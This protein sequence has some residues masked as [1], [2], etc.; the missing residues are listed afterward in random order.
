MKKVVKELLFFVFILL[1]I[2]PLRVLALSNETSYIGI[3]ETT[4]LSVGDLSFTNL[5]FK[6]YSDTSSL[7][8][9]V[10]GLLTN[11]SS[12]EI[13]YTSLV[14]Y[15]DNSY[16]LIASS[17]NSYKAIPDLTSFNQMSNLSKLGDYNVSDVSYFKLLIEINSDIQETGNISNLA[18]SKNSKYSSYD[19]VIDK[20][21][22]NIIVNENNT[23]DI[24]E[25]IT[26]YFN[27]SKH[28]IYRTIPLKNKITR[29]DGTTS[30][31]KVQVTNV[32]VDNEYTTSKENGNYKIKIGSSNYT[33]T[34]EKTYT[35]KYTY[36]LGKDPIKDYDE[37]YY[38]II[39]SE[40]D[41]VIGNVTFSITMPK[42]FDA[43]KLGFS[44]GEFGSTDN[45]DVSY[46][47]KDNT[48]T[49]S[50]DDILDVG[51][52]L[53]VRCELEKGYFV[54]AGL[55]IN[56]FDYIL[57]LIPILL[58]AIAILIWY[59]YGRDDVVVETV[60]FYPPEGL[61]S[62][63]VGFLYK[64]E[65]E[66]KDVTSLLVYLANKGYLKIID[67]N[68]DANFDKVKLSDEEISKAKEKIVELQAKIEE[69]KSNNP[70]SSK[71]KYY[72][73]MI[74]IYKNIDTPVDYQ[75]YGV[76]RTMNS[77][78]IFD[79]FI[80]EDRYKI[81]KI[82]DYDGNNMF[83]RWFMDGLFEEGCSETSESKLF[84]N[85]YHTINRIKNNIKRNSKKVFE[86]KPK[87]ISCVLILLMVMSIF[88][89]LFVPLLRYN[90]FDEL[91][92]Y[93]FIVLFFLFAFLS[94]NLNNYS[95]AFK[96]LFNLFF[97]YFI[98]GFFWTSLLKQTLSESLINLPSII[99]NLT[100]LFGITLCLLFLDKR[101]PYGTEMLGKIRGFKNFLESAE[102]E[103]LD[104]LVLQNPTY[105]YD[106]LPYT[107]VLGVSK[108]WIK[109]FETMAL[110]APDWYD[111]SNFDLREFDRVMGFTMSSCE[112][113][114][115]TNSSNDTFISHNDSPNNTSS[116]GGGSS[117]GGSGGGGGGSW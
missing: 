6:N 58:L 39:G 49:G 30:T 102:K 52:A 4:S 63:E 85:F 9:G 111:S 110:Q 1:I 8:F 84:D 15:Y 45:S 104:A 77:S 10:S 33:F 25:T 92:F 97:V 96:I 50:Y 88:N 59:K 103:K 61:N 28:G 72:E 86:K 22:V 27:V 17:N 31:N 19:Y 108:T 48:I 47:V 101:T 24:T 29:L 68:T 57:Y 74:D 65:A 43:S 35:I 66:N 106:I 79:I 7:S 82:K 115:P 114:M 54:G 89:I 78:S 107:Y 56:Y 71:I 3:K 53:T 76:K 32:S 46:V 116:S 95:P 94:A 23:F 26:A 99:V 55:Q 105:F 60:E 5:S 73:N 37:L 44:S 38:N 18:P 109:K 34:G 117:G 93:L 14:Y 81:V 83:E 11:S 80:Q 69:E 113:A 64:G 12:N 13:N 67:S 87:K 20:Y 36:N 21:D 16:N 2:S 62:L 112:S 75:S 91:S 51:E 41:T 42:N 70:N 98:L 40:W 100:C 90:V